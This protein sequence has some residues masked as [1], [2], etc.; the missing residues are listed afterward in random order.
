MTDEDKKKADDTTSTSEETSQTDEDKKSNGVEDDLESKSQDIDFKKEADRLEALKKTE[1]DKKKSELEKAKYTLKSV[2]ERVKQ[3]GGDPDEVFKPKADIERTDFVTKKDLELI[4]FRTQARQLSA[5]DDEFKVIMWY[6]ENKGLS[7]EDAHLV[8]N[9]GK[10]KSAFDEIT[11]AG[12]NKPRTG[13]GESSGQKPPA[14]PKRM[15]KD[16]EAKLAR[17]GFKFNSKSGTYQAKFNEVWWDG[18][19]WQTRRIK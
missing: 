3:L 9:K 6:V 14:P 16:D 1:E 2:A 4:E 8:A 17:D 19:D 5:S 7:V 10:I 18:S 13:D 15:S 11:R 12:N